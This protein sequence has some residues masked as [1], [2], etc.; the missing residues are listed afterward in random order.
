MATH[1]LL[2][3]QSSQRWHCR[4]LWSISCTHNGLHYD[5]V[6]KSHQYYIDLKLMKKFLTNILDFDIAFKGLRCY[7]CVLILALICSYSVNNA[8][9]YNTSMQFPTNE[10]LLVSI[11]ARNVPGIMTLSFYILGA[12]T[13]VCGSMNASGYDD[14]FHTFIQEPI[15]LNSSRCFVSQSSTEGPRRAREECWPSFDCVTSEWASFMRLPVC[16]SHITMNCEQDFGDGGLGVTL[17]LRLLMH[18]KV[19]ASRSHCLWMNE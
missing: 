5:F 6:M 18:G 10:L 8:I 1:S 16:H 9:T 17:T 2:G 12:N 15:Y 4:C 7:K 13:G 11:V 14:L 3:P 19:Q